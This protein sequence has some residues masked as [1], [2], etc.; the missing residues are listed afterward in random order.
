[1]MATAVS[2]AR[3]R[4]SEW[5][6]IFLSFM[7]FIALFL[8]LRSSIFLPP[9]MIGLESCSVAIGGAVSELQRNVHILFDR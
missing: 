4:S 5:S 9:W 8:A 7:M 2:E 6:R 1:M 3:G